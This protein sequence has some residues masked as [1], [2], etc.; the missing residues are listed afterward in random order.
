MIG[1]A[2]GARDRMVFFLGGKSLGN[3]KKHQ[4]S[5]IFRSKKAETFL[6]KTAGFMP[7]HHCLLFNAI[8]PVGDANTA[9]S[10]KITAIASVEEC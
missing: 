8:D 4:P 1:S 7:A 2:S 9:E 5:G 10:W 3:G 6:G